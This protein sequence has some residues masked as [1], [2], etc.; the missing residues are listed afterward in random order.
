VKTAVLLALAATACSG[1]SSSGTPRDSGTD[2]TAI[3]D[4]GGDGN[5]DGDA[6]AS[7]P[8]SDAATPTNILEPAMGAWWGFYGASN[9]A[10]ATIQTVEGDTGRIFDIA[11]F[12]HDFSNTGGSGVFPTTAEVALSNGG[13][14]L[15]IAWETRVYSNTDPSG[16]PAPQ[17]MYDGAPTYTYTYDQINSGALDTYLTTVAGRMKAF[18]K[19]IFVD[20]DHEME[21]AFAGNVAVYKYR[22]GSFGGVPPLDPTKYVNAYRHIV[23]LFRAQGVT[24]VVWV[25]VYAGFEPTSFDATYA[26]LYPGDDVVDWIGWDP[27]N[28][29]VAD[30]IDPQPL[31]SEF[32]TRIDGNLFQTTGSASKPR[33]LGEYGCLDDPSQPTRRETWFQAIPAALMAL[34]NLHALQYFDSATSVDFRIES[35]ANAL[36]GFGDAGSSPWVNQTHL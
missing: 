21:G 15:H 11:K 24:N 5:G 25:V 36:A 6:E 14:Y 8:Q 31:F 13:R 20:F 29:A 2:V 1:D 27:Y 4:G 30:W 17:G 10:N 16:M 18:A 23:S 7:A 32:Y 34:P 26:Q 22:I 3:V 9:N 28:D 19:P 33:M 12:Y 35:D